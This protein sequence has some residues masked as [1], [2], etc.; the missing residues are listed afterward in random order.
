MHL[1]LLDILTLRTL[2]YIAYN[3]LKTIYADGVRNRLRIHGNM[4]PNIRL[5]AQL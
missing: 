5:L 1:V 3:I 2:N 4:V